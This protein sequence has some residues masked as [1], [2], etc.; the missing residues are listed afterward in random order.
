MASTP[1]LVGRALNDTYRVLELVGEG[2]FADVF[3]GRDL[4]TNVPV[5]VKILHEHLGRD[6]SVVNRFLHEARVA[7]AL[8]DSHIVKVLDFGLDGEVHYIIMEYVTGHTLAHLLKARGPM[9]VDQAVGY[10]SQVL[11]AL[12]DAHRHDI[13]HR[14]IKP[15]NIMVTANGPVKVMDFGIAK[16]LDND[17]ATSAGLL[18][19]TPRYMSPE[20]ARGENATPASDVY[21][22]TITFYELLRGQP[23]FSADTAWKILNLHASAAP[24]PITDFRSDVPDNIQRVIAKGLAK[25]P[26]QRFANADEMLYAF[27]H[28]AMD[29]AEDKTVMETMPPVPAPVEPAPKPQPVAP[30]SPGPFVPR[31]VPKV[32]NER[33]PT[34]P[35]P[36]APTTEKPVEK[37]VT[38][39]VD[40]VPPPVKPPPPKP[41]VQPEPRPVDPKPKTTPTPL[42]AD[43][44]DRGTPKKR[45]S[46]PFLA[47]GILIIVVLILVGLYLAGGD[48]TSVDATPTTTASSPV[49]ATAT[50]PAAQAT[51]APT[52]NPTAA[53]TPGESGAAD[54]AGFPPAAGEADAFQFRANSGVYTLQ[55]QKPN[56]WYV[57]FSKPI[58]GTTR[59]SVQAKLTDANAKGSYLIF[60]RGDTTQNGYLFEVNPVQGTFGLVRRVNGE[61]TALISPTTFQSINRG[62]ASNQLNVNVTGSSINLVINGATIATMDDATFAKGHIGLGGRAGD[63]PATI[64]YSH[65][66]IA[67]GQ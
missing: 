47:G 54:A 2:G 43:V 28:G 10:M 44:L 16:D 52:A 33:P 41:P 30:V 39:P 48:D 15:Q 11:Q 32:N 13:V 60:F 25:D 5:A 66:E 26:S 58:V 21:A 40:T 53:S 17:G 12:A 61:D 56:S 7:Q 67:P 31:D 63:T 1:G 50:A 45:S 36:P 14:D 18:V 59:I 46:L 6:Q 9:P 34:L 42:P 4:R 19:G 64:E 24:P 51:N 38:K 55:I 35:K 20:Q 65:L 57:V 37:P 3:L 29:P 23:P 8:S 22:L 49:A 27:Q 62:G